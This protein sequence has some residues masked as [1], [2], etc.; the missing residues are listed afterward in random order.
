ME[1]S[2]GRILSHECGDHLIHHGFIFE[3]E[4][5]YYEWSP[6]SIVKSSRPEIKTPKRYICRDFKN[7]E[8]DYPKLEQRNLHKWNCQTTIRLNNLPI[9]EKYLNCFL[10]YE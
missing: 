1:Y 7:L 5:K 9:S 8:K 6:T 2:Y 3:D 10:I 4:R